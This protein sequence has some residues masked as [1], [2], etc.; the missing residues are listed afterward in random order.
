MEDKCRAKLTNYAAIGF[1]MDHTFLR[2]KLRNFV[3]LVYESTAKYL[4]KHLDYS[5]ELFPKDKVEAE[6]LHSM[7]FRAVFDHQTG[8]LLKIGW[9][10]LIL[11]GYH[12]MTKLTRE[13]IETQY[14]SYPRLPDYHI[15]SNRSEHFT[16][17]HEFYGC[18]AVPTLAKLVELKKHATSGMLL[19]KTFYNIMDD[20]KESWEFNY[21]VNREEFRKGI[22]SGYF[23]PV[24]LKNPEQFVYKQQ[25]QILKKLVEIRAKGVLVF[26]SSNST[27]EVA[28][29]FMRESIGE[30][31]LKIF[32]FVMYENKKPFF[33]RK[34]PSYSL[35]Q[36]LNGE[37]VTNFS[38]F[39]G[40][41]KDGEDKV[42]IGGHSRHFNEYL[43]KKAGAH[44]KVLFFGDTIVSDC[45]YSYDKENSSNWDVALILEEM[46]ELGDFKHNEY[47]DYRDVWGSALKEKTPYTDEDCTIIYHFARHVANAHFDKLDSLACLDYLTL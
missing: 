40:K 2:Y 34:Q 16:N 27:F 10:D 28:D 47:H 15:L 33:F 3:E 45:V 38:E 35:F 14:G 37:T 22:Y 9:G 18:A 32:D 39:I 26:I 21:G 46:Q 31:W 41:H 30:D 4:V 12:G 29:I 5:E 8:N 6:H 20:V 36:N 24:I 17:L 1:D 25:K 13:E 43:T 7:F 19:Q 11:R 23:F 42:L 44:F